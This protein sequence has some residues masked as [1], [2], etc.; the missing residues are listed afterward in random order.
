MTRSR[1]LACSLLILAAGACS[2]ESSSPTAP[3][4]AAGPSAAPA[5][6]ASAGPLVS[7]QAP[8]RTATR[9]GSLATTSSRSSTANGSEPPAWTPGPVRNLRHLPG[10][11]IMLAWDPPEDNGWETIHPVERYPVERDGVRVET[12]MAFRCDATDGCMFTSEELEP[13][14]YTFTVRAENGE[15]GPATSIV[16][17]LAGD[18]PAPVRDLA[19]EQI[20]GENGVVL[21]WKPP[22][23]DGQVD[24]AVIEYD[25]VGD[26]YRYS[27]VPASECTGSGEDTTCSTEQQHL[28][29]PDTH[30]FTVAA[31]NSAG[32]GSATGVEVHVGETV[33]FTASFTDAPWTHDGRRQFWIT[34]TFSEDF[35]VSFRTIRRALSI[36]GGR[37]VRVRRA[38]RGSNIEWRVRIRPNGVVPINVTLQGDRNCTEEDALCTTDGRRLE[39]TVTVSII[40]RSTE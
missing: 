35:R 13:G 38:E 9:I 17:V 12:V 11:R 10:S 15:A 8:G 24:E 20:P 1:L 7:R 37:I 29:Y 36:S 16:A 28:S 4:P 19:G 2:D 33:P 40:G 25:V 30:S 14:S 26:T 6:M 5:S 3:S 39:D 27:T 32:T 34:L 31:V 18:V 21:T 22:L 23:A